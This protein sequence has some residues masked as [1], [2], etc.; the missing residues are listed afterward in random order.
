MEIQHS[1]FQIR[2]TNLLPEDVAATKK[3]PRK[4][5]GSM[6]NSTSFN[7]IYKI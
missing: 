7:F 4:S 1:T 6:L 5:H 2:S 3:S